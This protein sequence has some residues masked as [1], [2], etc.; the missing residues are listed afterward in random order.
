M[1]DGGRITIGDDVLLGPRVG[2]YTTNHALDAGERVAGACYAQPVVIEDRVWV[3]GGVTIN[4]GV[5]IGEGAVIGSGSVVTRSV[6]PHTVAAGVPATVRREITEA[7]RT[8]Y[9]DV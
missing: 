1:L 3:G 6:P 7:D 8:G 4:K 9:L 2:I 5:T